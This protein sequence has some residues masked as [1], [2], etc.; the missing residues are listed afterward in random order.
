MRKGSK[1]GFTLVELLVVIAII[2]ILIALLLPAVQSAREAAR[3]TQCL[4]NLHQTALG[5]QNYHAANKVLPPAAKYAPNEPTS[6]GIW[7]DTYGWYF[8][9]GPY[10]DDVA[11]AASIH[12]DLSFSDTQNYAARTYKNKIFE[13]PSDGMMHNEWIAPAGF[14]NWARWRAN[15]AVNCGNLNYGQGKDFGNG[16]VAPPGILASPFSGQLGPGGIP[17]IITEVV[18]AVAQFKG[19]PF[20][21][22]RS[23]SLKKITDGTSHT[24]MMGEIRTIKWGETSW[25]G[26]IS[27]L[28]TAL[29]GQT[30]E[31]FLPPNSLWGDFSARIGYKV[32]CGDGQTLLDDAAMDGVPPCRCSGNGDAG[33]VQQY[34]A[35]RSKHRGI[36][37]VSFCDGS[38]HPISNSIDIQTWR[39]L[40][41]AEGGESGL[42]SKIY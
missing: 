29:G 5:M 24:L 2:G 40:S 4:N 6:G 32:S 9:M 41:T 18:P 21:I 30:F 25:G 3:R 15:Y 39:A 37:N 16:A 8:F 7:Y 36:V 31:A 20:S 13:C 22:K 33:T 14:M 17:I 11:W 42:D 26:P 23:R 19:A 10:L 27:E 38:T 34:F 1:P 28:E 35:A 12:I